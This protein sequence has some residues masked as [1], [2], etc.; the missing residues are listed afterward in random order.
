MR[1]GLTLAPFVWDDGAL[2][3]LHFVVLHVVVLFH[4]V[5]LRKEVTGKTK[6]IHL[7]NSECPVLL[8]SFARGPQKK[9]T[10]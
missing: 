3:I 5:V 1:R 6:I 2:V 7:R 8:A 9:E 10:L 4:V